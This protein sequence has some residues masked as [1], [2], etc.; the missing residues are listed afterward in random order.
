MSE[1]EAF[2]ECECPCGCA[3]GVDTRGDRCPMC[4]EACP[5]DGPARHP[6]LAQ[7]ASDAPTGEAP[8]D[9]EA[10]AEKA[11]GTLKFIE[12]AHAQA[13][14]GLKGAQQRNTVLLFDVDQMRKERDTACVERDEARSGYDALDANWAAMHE[15]A[16]MAIRQA[17]QAQNASVPEIVEA[18]AALTTE[19]DAARKNELD[20]VAVYVEAAGY[21][22]LAQLIR[23]LKGG[24]A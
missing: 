5:P 13:M 10:R 24:A 6:V 19:R 1:R 21:P 17:I 7:P 16:M 22:G 20:K 14:R 4:E 8:E 23:A 12:Q 9:A 2:F 3:S 15:A 11:E 18:I